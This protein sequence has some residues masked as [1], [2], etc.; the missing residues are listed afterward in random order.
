MPAAV[1][2]SVMGVAATI[3]WLAAR[4][5]VLPGMYDCRGATAV[6]DAGWPVVLAISAALPVTPVSVYARVLMMN[7]YP[8]LPR[9]FT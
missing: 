3:A 4:A 7:P 6:A 8:L 5:E 9:L 2:V 1:A